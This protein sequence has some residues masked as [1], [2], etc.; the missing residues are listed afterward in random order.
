M[1]CHCHFSISIEW[2]HCIV[3]TYQPLAP[4]LLV[5]FLFKI[6]V[7]GFGFRH[8]VLESLPP[9]T[10]HILI[11][12]LEFNGHQILNTFAL[13]CSKF[14]WKKR[15]MGQCRNMMTRHG[16]DAIE[17]LDFVENN[18]YIFIFLF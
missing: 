4:E 6:F 10:N 1:R 5:Y 9:A 15:V 12:L 7:R 13:L 16:F 11:K 3:R 14:L 8:N 2:L 17:Y 18:V